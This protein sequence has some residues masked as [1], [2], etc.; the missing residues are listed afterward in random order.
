MYLLGTPKICRRIEAPAAEA[1]A[2]GAV[3]FGVD[4]PLRPAELNAPR[5]RMD[6]VKRWGTVGDSR[7]MARRIWWNIG[8]IWQNI[9][10]ILVECSQG[11]K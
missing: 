1:K 7:V 5:A 6:M 9:G 8:R 10:R 4:E 3:G 11:L 2:S